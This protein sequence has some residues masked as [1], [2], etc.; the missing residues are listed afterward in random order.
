MLSLKERQALNELLNGPLLS[1][2]RHPVITENHLKAL[3]KNQ[4]GVVDAIRYEASDYDPVPFNDDPFP[5][6]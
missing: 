6:D 4:K 3:A 5:E 2:T 1:P